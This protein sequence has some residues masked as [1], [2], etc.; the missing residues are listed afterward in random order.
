MDYSHRLALSSKSLTVLPAEQ[1]FKAFGEAEVV[2]YTASAPLWTVLPEEP[3]ARGPKILIEAN[4]RNP[5]FS[6]DL[7][8]R[9][10]P[11]TE[12]IRGMASDAGCYGLFSDDRTQP[13][14]RCNGGCPEMTML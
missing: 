13:R 11:E 14:L 9:I 12:L 6:A 3:L 5:S 10:C 1:F 8:S 4:Y 2:I 7:L